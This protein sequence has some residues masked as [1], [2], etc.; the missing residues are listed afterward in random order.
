MVHIFIIRNDKN[1]GGLRMDFQINVGESDFET[2]K[3]TNTYYVDKTEFIYEL[4]QNTKNKVSL[5]TRP[6][7]FGKTLMM[8]MMEN[9][10]SVRKESSSI[11]EGLSITKHTDFCKSWMNRYPVVFISLKTVEDNSFTGAYNELKEVIANCCKSLADILENKSLDKDDVDVFLKLKAKVSEEVDVKNSLKTITR[12]LYTVYRKKVI[13]LIDEYDVPLAKAQKNGYYDKMLNIIKGMMNSSLKDNEFLQF[14]VVTGCLKIAK[15]SIFTGTNN[16]KSYS[17][18]DQKFSGYFGFSEAEVQKMLESLQISDKASV[19]KEWYDGYVFGSSF[20]YCP[21]DVV[22]YLSDLIDSS[23]ELPQNYW[24]NTSHNDI[25]IQF[26]KRKDLGVLDDFETLLN[27]GTI[28]CKISDSLT[29]ENLYSSKENLWSVLLMTGYVTKARP[30]QKGKTVDLK[31]PNKEISCIFENA[32][33]TWFQDNIDTTKQK[34]MMEAFWNGDDKSLTK[35]ISEF[36]TETISYHDY[37]EDYY[38]AF[39][40]GLF[41]GLGYT[42]K[43]NTEEGLGRPDI[44][45]RDLLKQRLIVIEAKKSKAKAD[46]SLD[47]DKAHNQIIEKEYNKIPV[48]YNSILCYAVAFFQKKAMVK[49]VCKDNL[50]G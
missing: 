47:C 41:V 46:M 35:I 39:L 43:S 9:F 22:N 2:L 42:V 23:N 44:Q 38:H 36:L 16:F 18:L 26:A 13:L 15:E 5:F 20:L 49:L 40:T 21:W 31:I 48:G 50:E 29:Y 1:I 17:V 6:R 10:F 32:V 25:V 27:D 4:V 12:M 19:I 8:S 30:D 7:R 28:S 33:I 14:A 24:E 11:F 45:I 34:K 3:K 37:H